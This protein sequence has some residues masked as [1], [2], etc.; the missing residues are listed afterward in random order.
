MRVSSDGCKSE[1][2]EGIRKC[3]PAIISVT[4][5]PERLLCVLRR[6]MKLLAPGV[7]WDG[8]SPNG[9]L[10]GEYGLLHEPGGK[11]M[12]SLASGVLSRKNW[13]LGLRFSSVSSD[14]EAIREGWELARLSHLQRVTRSSSIVIRATHNCHLYA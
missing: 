2:L 3:L 6:R 14:L 12:M 11:A 10:R 1:S 8:L 9:L 5:P 7:L 4:S 13:P